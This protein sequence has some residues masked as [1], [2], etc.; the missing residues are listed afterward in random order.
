MPDI[1]LYLF[2]RPDRSTNWY[3]SIPSS[4]GEI[5][6]LFTMAQAESKPR[7]AAAKRGDPD[8][9]KSIVLRAVASPHANRLTL[10]YVLFSPSSV[11]TLRCCTPAIFSRN[12]AALLRVT[13]AQIYNVLSRARLTK[14][15]ARRSLAL[16]EMRKLLSH[17]ACAIS[18]VGAPIIYVILYAS[19]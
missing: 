10:V 18:P 4:R 11:D 12:A 6:D 19:L 14:I 17:R 9:R 8:A 16:L 3:I 13:C 15:L 2:K 5:T 1:Y 7:R